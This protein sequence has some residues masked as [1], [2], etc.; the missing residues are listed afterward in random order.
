VFC[1]NMITVHCV[2]MIAIGMYAL[3]TLGPAYSPF[4]QSFR[5][6]IESDEVV[7]PTR[8][9]QSKS[10][11][12][13]WVKPQYPWL[14]SHDPT[15]LVPRKINNIFW[16]NSECT[17]GSKS[18]GMCAQHFRRIPAWIR[19]I[20]QASATRRICVRCASCSPRNHANVARTCCARSVQQGM[21]ILGPLGNFITF[22]RSVIVAC[23]VD[24]SCLVRRTTL[25]IRIFHKVSQKQ[26]H[27]TSKRPKPRML[28]RVNSAGYPDHQ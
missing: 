8:V 15:I 16:P 14:K 20:C 18:N 4:W 7:A 12:L 2:N 25:E 1:R 3:A 27:S 23:G 22:D 21:L 11:V 6:H 19:R 26:L 5:S 13:S 9:L 17:E 24:V 28:W 10:S